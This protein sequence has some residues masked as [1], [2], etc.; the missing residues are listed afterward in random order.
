MGLNRGHQALVVLPQNDLLGQKGLD[1]ALGT[2]WRG[3]S[4]R[5]RSATGAS[6]ELTS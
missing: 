6:A 1:L 4:G 5:Q 2:H 3:S